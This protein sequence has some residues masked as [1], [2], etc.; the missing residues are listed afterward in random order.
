V[1]ALVERSLASG[2]GH[3]DENFPVASHLVAPRYRAPIMAFYRFAR[4]AD[5]IADHPGAAAEIKAVRL[6]AMRATLSGAS[7]AN[8]EALALRDVCHAKGLETRHGLDL[9]TAFE[10]DV[11][12]DR[13]ADWDALIDYCRVSAMPVGRFVLDVHGEGRA[14]WA[15]SDTL[16]A[17]LQVINHTQD[18]AKDYRA[19]GRVYL[20]LDRL[21][22]HGGRVEDLAGPHATPG[23]RATI[24]EMA[25]RSRGLLDQAAGFAEAIR[26]T[27]LAAEVAVIHRLAVSLVGRLERRDPLCERVHH[28]KPEAALLALGAVAHLIWSR[29]A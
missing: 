18:C 23:L 26:D 16:C 27:R 28:A 25:A 6:A 10:R 29:I 19:N 21:A 20:P 11:T 12:V 14:T 7:D 5:D 1:T 8:P 2:K 15:A 22:A 9:L 4:A 17:A 24:I 3:R 13:C